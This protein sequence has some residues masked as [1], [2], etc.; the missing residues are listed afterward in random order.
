MNRTN[1]LI[2]AS[3]AL[4]VVGVAFLVWGFSRQ[5]S[6]LEPQ[7]ERT[8]FID[9]KDL[10]LYANGE[11]GF[12]LVYPAA[13]EVL[14]P[15]SGAEAFP[16]R[17]GANSESGTPTASFHLPAGELRIGVGESEEARRAC[18]TSAPFEQS[19]GTRTLGETTWQVFIFEQL[20]MENVRGIT[21]YRVLHGE[22][23]FAIETLLLRADPVA[24]ETADRFDFMLSNFSFAR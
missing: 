9:Q 5:S 17:T 1:W 11:F 18:L 22:Q 20:G 10:S 3:I 4:A 8:L 15:A 6:V 7:D 16:W 21:S 24:K 19:A 14:D 2:V 12:S 13:A 23:C